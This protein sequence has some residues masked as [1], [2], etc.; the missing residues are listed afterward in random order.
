M[1]AVVR[2]NTWGEAKREAAADDVAEFD[3]I[4]AGQPGF[5]GS[6]VVDV[7]EGREAIVNLWESED[8]AG[9]ALAVVGPEVG[10]LLAPL[11][12]GPS[13]LIGTGEVVRGAEL[14]DGGA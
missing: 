13:Q 12:A 9:A 8:A 2:V 11:M 10:R 1:Y 4:H 7:G 3:R 6:I 14:V 5:V